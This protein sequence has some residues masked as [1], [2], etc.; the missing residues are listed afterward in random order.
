VEDIAMTA[1]IAPRPDNPFAAFDLTRLIDGAARLRPEA[2]CLV[3]GAITWSAR[4]VVAAADAFAASLRELGLSARDRI[5]LVPPADARGLIALFGAGKAGLDIALAPLDVDARKL[6]AYAR[7][8]SARAVIGPAHFAEMDVSQRLFEAAAAADGV[9]IVATFGPEAIDGAVHLDPVT[10][11]RG[12]TVAAARGPERAGALI[13]LSRTRG[14]PRAL[15][16]SAVVAAAYDFVATLGARRDAPMLSLMQPASFAGLVA[17]PVAA[18]LAG[19]TL[20]LCAPWREDS[21]KAMVATGQ[22]RHVATPAA[23]GSL[24][25]ELFGASLA[26]LT[27]ATR[28]DG[29]FGPTPE[30]LFASCPIIDLYA[31]GDSAVVPERRSA[32]GAPLPPANDPHYVTFDGARVLSVRRDAFGALEGA[33]VNQERAP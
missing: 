13:L 7:A 18:L 27:L 25:A 19:A 32:G 26:S 5:V 9:Q 30:P 6:G 11:S 3:D 20:H 29:L 12:A 15:S 21:L 4:E 28:R 31:I 2:P 10:L 22:R 33:A 1:E 8:V 24:V 14:E 16:Q 17:G 23:L